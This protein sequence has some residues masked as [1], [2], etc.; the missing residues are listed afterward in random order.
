MKSSFYITNA[1]RQFILKDGFTKTVTF[2]NLFDID[3]SKQ[4]IF[5]LAHLI[6]GNASL[7]GTTVIISYDVLFMDIVQEDDSNVED[8]LNT[9]LVLANRLTSE[10]I[11]GVLFDD[12]IQVE[13]ATAEPFIDRFENKLAGWALSFDAVIPNNMNIY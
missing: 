6:I 10:L 1:V 2:G 4:S 3:L 7:N 5:P 13:N 11:R 12:L 9:Q 8:I